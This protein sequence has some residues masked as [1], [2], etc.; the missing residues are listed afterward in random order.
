MTGKIWVLRRNGT[1][2]RQSATTV[3]YQNNLYDAGD[4]LL[5]GVG[6]GGKLV[7][8]PLDVDGYWAS[9]EERANPTTTKSQISRSGH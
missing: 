1:L 3:A 2:T 9:S 5:S 6:P 8:A 4:V 7:A